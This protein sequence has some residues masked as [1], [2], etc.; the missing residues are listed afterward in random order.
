MQGK[1]VEF[2]PSAALVQQ[3]GEQ[4]APEQE[5][6]VLCKLRAKPNGNWCFLEVDGIA[7]PGYKDEDED[8]TG[9]FARSYEKARGVL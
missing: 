9:S 6:E 2:K 7:M 5:F 8:K 4:A 1:L 3:V